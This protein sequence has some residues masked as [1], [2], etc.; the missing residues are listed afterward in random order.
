MERVQLVEGAP[1]A[2][3]QV[4]YPGLV[5]LAA[6]SADECEAAPA[7]RC[8]TSDWPPVTGR[9]RTFRGCVRRRIAGSCS[10]TADI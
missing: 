6:P 5:P 4:L 8:S 9:C 2:G 7:V 3:G 1:I 10:P